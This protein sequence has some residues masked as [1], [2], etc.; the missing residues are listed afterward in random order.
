MAMLPHQI[1]VYLKQWEYTV[2][3]CST[4]VSTI[5]LKLMTASQVTTNK[6]VLQSLMNRSKTT[7]SRKLAPK[8]SEENEGRSLLQRATVSY[9]TFYSCYN[10]DLPFI[11]IQYRTRTTPA[12]MQVLL[13]LVTFQTRIV[14]QISPP[15][16]S[17]RKPATSMS[18]LSRQRTGMG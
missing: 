3:N 11:L 18:F 17:W 16:K 15:L 1:L 2:R 6:K 5:N 4:I 14:M 13:I 12:A 9:H 8:K 10:N 7:Q